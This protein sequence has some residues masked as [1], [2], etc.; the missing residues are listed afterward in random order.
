[1]SEQ[2][3][4][5]FAHG[6]LAG[7]QEETPSFEPAG[8]RVRVSAAVELAGASPGEISRISDSLVAALS[9]KD[10]ALGSSSYDLSYRPETGRAVFTIRGSMELVGTVLS[11][12]QNV[13]G[14]TG[15]EGGA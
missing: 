3:L 6:E 7:G 15:A 5:E 9:G 12:L 13:V 1:M 11:L 2:S 14:D 4:K 10:P 8:E